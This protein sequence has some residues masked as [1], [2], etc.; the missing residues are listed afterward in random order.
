LFFHK[1]FGD[2]LKLCITSKNTLCSTGHNPHAVWD[3]LHTE[4]IQRDWAP[5]TSLRLQ[6][7]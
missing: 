7:W 4:L 6:H 5:V 3:H 1:T 2:F